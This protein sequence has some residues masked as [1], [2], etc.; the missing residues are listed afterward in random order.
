[1]LLSLGDRG[2]MLEMRPMLLLSIRHLQQVYLLQIR[3]NS[4]PVTSLDVAAEMRGVLGDDDRVN[5][6]SLSGDEDVGIQRGV[7]GRWI[8]LLTSDG[9]ELGRVF[10]SG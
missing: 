7:A 10:P 4:A 8:A 5:E 1:M 9:P 3:G 6:L 2:I